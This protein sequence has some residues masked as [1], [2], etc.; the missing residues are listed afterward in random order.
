M[1]NTKWNENHQLNWN[2]ELEFKKDGYSGFQLQFMI[3]LKILFDLNSIEYV[4][5]VSE[6][7]DLLDSNKVVK[8][9]VLTLKDYSESQI[10]IYHDMAEYD[11][12]KKHAI[13]EEWGYISPVELRE[14][15]INSLREVLK[16]K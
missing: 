9:I 12:T 13:F 5:K 1:F 10:W 16:I 4:E 3:E 6:N 8:M 2:S 11:I 14:K 7:I 15:F